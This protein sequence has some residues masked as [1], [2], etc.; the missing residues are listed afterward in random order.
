MEALKMGELDFTAPIFDNQ[1][2]QGNDEADIITTSGSFLLR[3]KFD[4][5][6]K[7]YKKGVQERSVC[8]TSI[9]FLT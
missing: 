9:S 3:F 7:D 5:V 8:H 2:T 4:L 1:P 6:K